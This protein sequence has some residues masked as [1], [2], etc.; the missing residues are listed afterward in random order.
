MGG[1]DGNGS[2]WRDAEKGLRS[3]EWSQWAIWR[4]HVGTSFTLAGETDG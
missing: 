1:M 3:E 4:V 2:W